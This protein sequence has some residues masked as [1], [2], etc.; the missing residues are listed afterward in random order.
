MDEFP[1]SMSAYV[2]DTLHLSLEQHGAYLLIMMTMRRA[3]GWLD[4]D[5]KKLARICKITVARWRR[6]GPEVCALMTVERGRLTQKRVLKDVKISLEISQKNSANGKAGGIAK[7]LKNKGPP[8]ATATVLP[9]MRHNADETTLLLSSN[10]LDSKEGKKENKKGKNRGGAALPSD[11][12]P[13]GTEIEYGIG[14]CGLTRA[15][16]DDCAEEMR[17]WAIANANRQVGRKDNWSAAFMGWMRRYMEKKQ[18]KNGGRRETDRTGGQQLGFGT[19]AA[20]LRARR[21]ARGEKV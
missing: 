9:V 8:I 4:N 18:Q 1:L 12:V 2:A 11:W 15:E 13:S 14:K 3:G 20:E 17:L 16:I 19:L 5:E 21:E 6:I 7:S 10:N